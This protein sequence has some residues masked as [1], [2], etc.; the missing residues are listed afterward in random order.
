M[1]PSQCAAALI[2]TI[3]GLAKWMNQISQQILAAPTGL[4]TGIEAISPLT[5]EEQVRTH[6]YSTVFKVSINPPGQ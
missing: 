6:V 4:S 1:G 2:T 3:A 5:H